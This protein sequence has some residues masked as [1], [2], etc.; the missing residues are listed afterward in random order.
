MHDGAVRASREEHR[1]PSRGEPPGSRRG[2]EH[3][4]YHRA[5]LQRS[6]WTVPS[7]GPLLHLGEH[8]ESRP[9]LPTN[10]PLLG[11]GTARHLTG[12][13]L[14][15]IRQWRSPP[16]PRPIVE[17]A[18]SLE[19]AAEQPTSRLSLLRI[20]PQTRS[21]QLRC[22]GPKR[23]RL[24]SDRDSLGH[25]Q[26]QVKRCSRYECPFFCLSAQHRRSAARLRRAGRR[27]GRRRLVRLKRHVR[28][29]SIRLCARHCKDPRSEWQ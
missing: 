21:E 3:D 27:P 24:K 4:R 25:V 26:H 20:C 14:V 8:G 17:Q 29:R 6:R 12:R 7:L 5:H 18:R 9:R 23:Q 22:L 2:P 13:R 16:G 10:R 11:Y 28:H 19:G 1:S 15:R